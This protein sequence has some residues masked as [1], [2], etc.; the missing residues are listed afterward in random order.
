MR[1]RPLAILGIFASLLLA[2]CTF[3]LVIAP[4]FVHVMTT[5]YYGGPIFVFELTMGFW[6]VLRGLRRTPASSVA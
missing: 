5:T 2:T 1:P 4:A 6:L 3:A